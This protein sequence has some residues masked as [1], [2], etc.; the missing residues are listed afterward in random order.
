MKAL[1]NF[2]ETFSY[3]KLKTLL[4]LDIVKPC[5]QPMIKFL[6]TLGRIFEPC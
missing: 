2:K 3:Y 5:V 6:N 4:N 1:S